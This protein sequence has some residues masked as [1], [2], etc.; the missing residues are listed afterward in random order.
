MACA[1]K[2]QIDCSIEDWSLRNDE[3]SNFKLR[4][5]RVNG[6]NSKRILLIEDG[7]IINASKPERKLA[8]VVCG[9]RT[10]Q[11]GVLEEHNLAVVVQSSKFISFNSAVI[12]RRLLIEFHGGHCKQTFILA[13]VLKVDI[14]H[15]GFGD[16]VGA[17]QHLCW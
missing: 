16:L 10:F 1:H 12:E 4:K 2:L 6:R 13:S 14:A 17:I 9:G 11:E 5:H 15:L 8:L 7:W 3:V